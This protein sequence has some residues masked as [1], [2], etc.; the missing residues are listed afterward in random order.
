MEVEFRKGKVNPRALGYASI[1]WGKIAAKVGL[2]ICF[3]TV[4]FLENIKPMP[5]ANRS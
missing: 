5:F 1:A 3:K 4:G 2:I